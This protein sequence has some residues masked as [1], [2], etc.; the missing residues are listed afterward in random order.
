MLSARSSRL[1][2]SA[3]NR[4]LQK[5]PVRFMGTTKSFVSS[6]PGVI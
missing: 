4:L 6:V 3:V 5:Q 2:A 1:A